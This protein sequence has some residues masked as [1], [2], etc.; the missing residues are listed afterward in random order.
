MTKLR[1]DW[2]ERWHIGYDGTLYIARRKDGD[3]SPCP[4]AEMAASDPD[5]LDL[6]LTGWEKARASAGWDI[7]ACRRAF[8]DYTFTREQG[9]IVARRE[10][11]PTVRD[12]SHLVLLTLLRARQETG[13]VTDAQPPKPWLYGQ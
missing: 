8:P 3:G 7:A 12:T 5:T 9:Q 10:G 6:W 2:G 11:S 1:R 4:G 13:Q